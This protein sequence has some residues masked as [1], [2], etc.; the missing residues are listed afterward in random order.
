MTDDKWLEIGKIVAP[1]GIRGE[2]RIYPN[3][4]FPE[5]FLEPGRRWLRRTGTEEPEP[6][7]LLGGRYIPGKGIYAV[8]IAGIE[9][10]E[11]AEALRG[12]QMLVEMS[13][14]PTLEEDE[15]HI[16]DLIGLEVFNQVNGELLGTVVD[17]IPAGNDLLQVQLHQSPS[18]AAP[19]E[20]PEIAP[21]EAVHP[22]ARRGGRKR[23][24]QPKPS[25]PATVLIPFVKEIVPVVDL[26]SHRL[27]VIPP[28]GLLEI[29]SP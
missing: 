20:E 13:D 25:E 6:I 16:L 27:E 3:S 24:R 21:V 15:F 19:A 5:R 4:D 8:E 28:A 10:R 26:P 11:A 23:K 22:S 7:E 1:Q 2:V 29:E 14:R 12:S 17:V 9:D 18:S